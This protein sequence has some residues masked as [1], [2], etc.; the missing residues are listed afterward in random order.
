MFVGIDEE[1]RE[2]RDGVN[3]CE[4]WEFG[5]Y[6]PKFSQALVVELG[7]HSWRPRCHISVD[8]K[9]LRINSSYGVMLSII[10]AR[11]SDFISV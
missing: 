9:R 11:C 2:C 8:V 6:F 3:V 1:I 7:S 10:T 5:Q 4:S